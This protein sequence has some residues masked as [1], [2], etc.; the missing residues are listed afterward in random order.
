MDQVHA[1]ALLPQGGLIQLGVIGDVVD[2]EH[3]WRHHA[4]STVHISDQLRS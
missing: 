4:A 2:E 3:E 1:V